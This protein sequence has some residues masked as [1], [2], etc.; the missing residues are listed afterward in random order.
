MTDLLTVK[1]LLPA[2]AAALAVAGALGALVL[3]WDGRAVAA[4]LAAG[5][6]AAAVAIGAAAHVLSSGEPDVE[7]REHKGPGLARRRLMLGAGAGAAAVV[8]T[9]VSIPAVR[10]SGA[11][12]DRLRH[13][14]WLA[15]TRVVDASGDLVDVDAIA[16]GELLTVYPE[17]AVG[18]TRAQAVLVREA[19]A[20]FV[21]DPERQGWTPEGIVVYSKLCT[22]MA[23]PVGLYQQRTGTILCP[24]HQAVFDALDGGRAVA[25]PARRAL[26]QLP[27]SIDEDRHLVA[28]GDFSDAVG[29]GFWGRP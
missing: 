23:C 13:T 10:R 15:G 7:D 27:V 6:S 4:L 22:H 26:P 24:C 11:A 3:G 1:V 18:S 14:E 21:A 9:A 25:G 8:A 16:E 19:P 2:A 17:G 12:T 20:R 29:T 28:L 5:L